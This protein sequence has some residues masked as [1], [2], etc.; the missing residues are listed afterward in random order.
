MLLD[1]TGELNQSAT[2]IPTGGCNFLKG[3]GCLLE[4]CLGIDVPLNPSA[5]LECL[6]DVCRNGST[7]CPT[8]F[9]PIMPN[10][11]LSQ[12]LAKHCMGSRISTHT[13]TGAMQRYHRIV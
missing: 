9:L 1:S 7:N 3:L 13:A 11:M 6:L 5:A 2:E 4:L 12:D 8:R 10:V